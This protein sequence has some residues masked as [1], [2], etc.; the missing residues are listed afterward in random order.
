MSVKSKVAAIAAGVLVLM[1]LGQ[2]AKADSYQFS[3]Q[4]IPESQHDSRNPQSQGLS[5]SGSGTFD[6]SPQCTQQGTYGSYTVT[7]LEGQLTENGQT[8]NMGFI[9]SDPCQ[10]FVGGAAVS[11]TPI[12]DRVFFTVDDQ[13]W[14]FYHS[15]VV[16]PYPFYVVDSTTGAGWAAS[17][18]DSP[19]PTP[20]PSTLLL[21]SMGLL[22]LMGLTRLK[23]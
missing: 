7:S 23:N 17:F 2:A 19:I 10:N 14:Y 6:A 9:F 16:S 5:I 21:L 18:T 11:G 20:E 13:L 22:G 12:R 15:S 1:L 8:Q 4:S 3:F